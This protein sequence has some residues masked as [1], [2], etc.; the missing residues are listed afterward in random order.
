MS[1]ASTSKKFNSKKYIEQMGL[2]PAQGSLH[3]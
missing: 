2:L 3:F 1:G